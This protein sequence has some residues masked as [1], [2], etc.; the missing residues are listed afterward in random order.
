ML[1]ALAVCA[2]YWQHLLGAQQEQRHYAEEQVRLRATRLADALS[3]QVSTL[4]SGLEYVASSLSTK[5]LLDPDAFFPLA[6]QTALRTF[7]K[8]SITQ[9][10]VVNAQGEVVYTNLGGKTDGSNG[11]RVSIADREHFRIHIDH[12]E[13]GTYIGHPVF[14]RVS[15]RWTIQV[16]HALRRNGEFQGVVVLSVSP[17]YI[18]GYFREIFTSDNDVAL[19]VYEDGTYLARSS[20]QEQTLNTKVPPDRPFLLER[21]RPAGSYE[22]A[23]ALDQVERF[24]AW[25]RISG[26]PLVVNIGLERAKALE[27]LTRQQQD[28]LLRNALGSVLILS[29]ILWV[30]LLVSRLRRGR[31]LLQE[32]EQ[33]LKLALQGGETGTW[34]WDSRR[35]L[36]LHD[37]AWGAMLGYGPG[38]LPADDQAMFGLV[39]PDDYAKVQDRVARHLRG[40]TSI[41]ESEH[42]MRHKD[43]HWVWV[44]VRGGI[45]SD[46]A[47]ADAPRLTGTQADISRSKV[48]ERLR[49]ALFDNSAAEILLMHP[50]DRIIKLANRRAEETF[51]PQGGSLTGMPV[52]MMH[53]DVNGYEQFGKV[54]ATLA[55][56]GRVQIETQFRNRHGELRWYSANGTLLDREVPDGEVIWTLLDITERK[57]MEQRLADAR[58][59]LTSVIEQFPGGVLVE[60]ERGRILVVNQTWCN[61]LALGREAATLIGTQVADLPVSLGPEDAAQLRASLPLSPAQAQ[62]GVAVVD[63]T[64]T[65]RDQVLQ[66]RIAAVQ[67]EGTSLGRLW[68]ANDI[69]A[70]VRRESDLTRRATTDALTGLSNRAAFLARLDAELALEGRFPDSPGILL[71]ADLDRFKLVNDTYGHAAGDE[72]LRFLAGVFHAVLRKTDLVGRLGGEEFSVLL[73]GVGESEGRMLAER[74]RTELERSAIPTQAGEVHI[75]ISIGMARLS[76]GSAAQIL[77]AADAALYKAKRNGRNRVEA[78]WE[79]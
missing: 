55:T 42:R 20:L 48:D 6:V 33:R 68:I 39:H 12:P 16:S 54:Y 62:G 28:A 71:M 45:A 41:F 5:Y 22:A 13:T 15:Q 52:S 29:F 30:A 11:A 50:G 40:E 23:P 57:R 34:S 24:Y 74:I 60:E 31:Q 36:F 37:D 64:L 44:S 56:E 65:Y 2:A 53:I 51:S 32:S 3:V 7:P 8:E 10:A 21:D 46:S 43:G 58:A 66:M 70:Q 35:R 49:E 4:F 75:T 25:R 27:T 18:S 72:V 26:Y 73:S 76:D 67:R 38:G 63:E 47:D 77:A 17:D 9:I 69:T 59:R 14:G 19:L 79:A 78:A 61:L 1:V